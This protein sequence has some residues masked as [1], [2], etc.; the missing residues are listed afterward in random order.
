MGSINHNI[1]LSNIAE[2]VPNSTTGLELY[3][4]LNSTK[5]SYNYQQYKTTNQPL[6]Y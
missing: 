6:I 2:G 5:N 1:L 3:N 4:N